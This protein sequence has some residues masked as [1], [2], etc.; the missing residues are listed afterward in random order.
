MKELEKPDLEDLFFS[1]C[2][3]WLE[4]HKGFEIRGE[5]GLLSL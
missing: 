4:S 5:Y 1:I 3:D 2:G